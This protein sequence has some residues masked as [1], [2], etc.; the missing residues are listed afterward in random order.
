MLGSFEKWWKIIARRE[1]RKRA[2][3]VCLVQLDKTGRVRIQSTGVVQFNVLVIEGF[4][5]AS[6]DWNEANTRETPRS[7]LLMLELGRAVQVPTHIVGEEVD[8]RP[9]GK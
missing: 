7:L 1:N 4:S 6:I 8:R 9:Y 2:V 3:I 5:I